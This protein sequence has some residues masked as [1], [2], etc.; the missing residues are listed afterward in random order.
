MDPTASSNRVFTIDRKFVCGKTDVQLSL[1]GPDND[2]SILAV[3][4]NE[5][6]PDGKLSL[7]SINLSASTGMDKELE[8]LVREA[9]PAG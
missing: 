4:K 9:Q 5:Q 2:A 7:G 8:Y 3:D 6:F 1:Q